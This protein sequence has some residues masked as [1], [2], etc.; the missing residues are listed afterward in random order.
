VS[1]GTNS[2][3]TVPSVYNKTVDQAK[4]ALSAAG[5]T[6]FEVVE[7]PHDTFA[8]G[9]IFNSEPKA[10]ES[11]DE[12]TKVILYVSSGPSTTVTEKLLVPSVEGLT[13]SGARAFLEKYGFTNINFVTQDSEYDK[14][15][16]ISQ[17]PSAGEYA[18]ADSTIKVI[19][20]S[21]ETTTK[22][23]PSVKASVTITLPECIGEDGKNVTDT[24]KISVGNETY[25]NQKV[26]LDGKKKIFSIYINSDMD[27][28]NIVVTLEDTGAIESFTI[29]ST[30][31]NQSF[32]VDF[33]AY[34]VDESTSD[35]ATSNE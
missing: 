8:E 20:S 6:N 25:L 24:L 18:T 22:A 17:S 29:D 7:Q 3:L 26:T 31:E 1:T 19:I 28:S 34:S 14:D 11:V 21:G 4:I 12:N 30:T 16:V 10:G 35:D 33:S 5:L 27:S 32:T 13:K 2:G 9:T 15:I 23:T